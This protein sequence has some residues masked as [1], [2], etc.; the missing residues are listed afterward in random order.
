MKKVNEKVNTMDLQR[1]KND[2]SRKLKTR[3]REQKQKEKER[4]RERDDHFLVFL[5]H[6]TFIGERVEELR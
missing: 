4:E 5:H 2:H 1:T 6:P 3:E